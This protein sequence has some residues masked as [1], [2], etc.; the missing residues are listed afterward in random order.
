MGA[1][2]IC[3]GRWGGGSGSRVR[4]GE[5]R[6]RVSG[7]G[8]D[9]Q[10]ILALDDR[11]RRLCATSTARAAGGPRLRP[12]ELWRCASGRGALVRSVGPGRRIGADAGGGPTGT[13]ARGRSGRARG[14]RSGDAARGGVPGWQ[15]PARRPAR[16]AQPGAWARQVPGAGWSR[17][18]LSQPAPA[19]AIGRA[20]RAR[21][22]VSQGR[23][24][25]AAQTVAMGLSRV[26]VMVAY[27]ARAAPGGWN[28]V[29]SACGG[30]PAAG[31]DVSRAVMRG[32]GPGAMPGCASLRR[33]RAV[34]RGL[35]RL[36]GD[37]APEVVLQARRNTEWL[38]AGRDAHALP[39]PVSPVRSGPF[40]LH[41]IDPPRSRRH[42]AGTAPR[43][44]GAHDNGPGC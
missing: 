18:A 21:A 7:G 42:R 9:C 10:A 8:R 33:W 1:G 28:T 3:R 20:R 31:A 35:S 13:V 19:P 24:A 23:A 25:D 40:H 43:Q 22:W 29:P 36:A 17:P 12:R 32:H 4:A 30:G 38:R 37:P 2:W 39:R 6:R 11:M 15:L 41:S 16:G 34:A 27:A 5:R 26:R 14:R 44:P